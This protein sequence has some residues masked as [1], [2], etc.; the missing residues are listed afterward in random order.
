MGYP[1]KYKKEY[2][3]IWKN[4]IPEKGQADNLQGELLRQLEKLRIEAQSNGNIN[5]C[6][7]FE[8]FCD[9]LESSICSNNAFDVITR[10]EK[11]IISDA[12]QRFKSAGRFAYRFNNNEVSDEELEE[13][14]RHR[15]GF[16]YTEDDLYDL[17]TNAI[18][19]FYAKY[20]IPIPYEANCDIYI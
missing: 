19:A 18:C 14:F 4:L 20:Q 15:D 12:L 13:E 7:D 11:E 3:Y 1:K 9:F 2:K 5:W 17:I 8:F 6:G 10:E 16:A